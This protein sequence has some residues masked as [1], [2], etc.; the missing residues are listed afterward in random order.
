MFIASKGGYIPEDA[1]KMISRREM[2]QKMIKE[3][4]VPENEIV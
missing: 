3:V 1:E 2:S 4:G